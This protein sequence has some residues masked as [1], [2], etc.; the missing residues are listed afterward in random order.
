MNNTN[1]HIKD[2]KNIKNVIVFGSNGML[3]KYISI[4]LSQKNFHVINITRNNFDILLSNNI[5]NDLENLLLTYNINKDYVVIN[6]IGLIP[7]TQNYNPLHYFTINSIF[8]YHLSQLS[9]KYN[10]KL[11]HPTTDCVFSGHK[12][13][14]NESDLK[15]E[16]SIYGLSK[17]LGENIPNTTIIRTSII[18]QQLH[19]N[20]SL[21][22][23][24]LSNKN[25]TVNGYTNHLWN[26][27][28]CLQFAKIIEYIINYNTF[29][30]GI[31]HVFS[32]E[33]VSK[34]QLLQLINNTYNLNITIKPIQTTKPVNKSLT[35]I[36]T[37]HNFQNIIP[38][39]QKQLQELYDFQS[40]LV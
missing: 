11:I 31:K 29:W 9:I 12:G 20:Y 22:Q 38:S 3:G 8:P 7:Q 18:G 15:N 32:N 37:S 5:L 14:Y 28:T 25:K 24:L 36:H 30:I 39:L 40:Y 27:I 6:C 10:F 23:W 1:T 16:T 21:L 4:Y 26:G 33:I 19:N 2:V 35:T 17:I 13:L 34:Y